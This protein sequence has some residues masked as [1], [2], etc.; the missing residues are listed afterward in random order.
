M[1]NEFYLLTFTWAKGEFCSCLLNDKAHSFDINCDKED[2]SH[3]IEA[4]NVLN[5]EESCATELGCLAESNNS[6]CRKNFFIVQVQK[7]K[8][9]DRSIA[10]SNCG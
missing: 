8:I 9:H 10:V 6:T 5:N 7:H 2:M 4:W 1:H 3:V